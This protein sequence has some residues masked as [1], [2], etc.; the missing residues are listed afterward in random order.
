MRSFVPKVNA[1]ADHLIAVAINVV[2]LALFWSDGMHWAFLLLFAPVT[3][4][5]LVGFLSDPFALLRWWRPTVS[6]AIFSVLL[7]IS[8]EESYRIG[9]WS[10]VNIETL[11]PQTA[12]WPVF[13]TLYGGRVFSELFFLLGA[14][15]HFI[16]V[17]F[18]SL[19]E[20]TA[21]A[22]WKESR[23]LFL[24]SLGY[25]FFLVFFGYIIYREQELSYG[26]RSMLFVALI[27]VFATGLV[28]HWRGQEPKELWRAIL[29]KI[30]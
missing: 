25:G 6:I 2:P 18:P 19:A 12:S 27:A 20:E 17:V 7:L 10:F 16:G 22:S 28:A 14:A 21:L 13:I 29:R 9:H 11:S 3:F 4:L 5:V 1:R 8:L 26:V 15:L 30:I 23:R 24:L